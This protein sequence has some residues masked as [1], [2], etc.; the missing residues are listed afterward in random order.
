MKKKHSCFNN[1]YLDFIIIGNKKSFKNLKGIK[2][3]LNS[4]ES[5]AG[6]SDEISA[7][8]DAVVVFVVSLWGRRAINLIWGE[9]LCFIMV[10]NTTSLSNVFDKK[11]INI[12]KCFIHYDILLLFEGTSEKE[13]EQAK[14]K[15]RE[16]DYGCIVQKV[17]RL[18]SFPPHCLFDFNRPQICNMISV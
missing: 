2:P 6:Y 1:I 15:G 13:A 16:Y 12:I 9:K 14:P 10:Y 8:N 7:M 5:G 3:T 18:S 4:A 11:N 17:T